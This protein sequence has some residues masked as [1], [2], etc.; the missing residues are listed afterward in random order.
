MELVLIYEIIEVCVQS[1]RLMV[2]ICST[3]INDASNFSLFLTTFLLAF[4]FVML[5]RINSPSNH[6]NFKLNFFCLFGED[7]S[8]ILSHQLITEADA[9][10]FS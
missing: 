1:I 6:S 2:K 4:L 3:E 7:Q 10:T 5:S 8:A 9:L